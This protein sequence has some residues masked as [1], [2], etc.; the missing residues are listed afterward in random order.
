ML[1]VGAKHLRCL[2]CFFR[3][4][5]KI[6]FS[7][8]GIHTETMPHHE[9]LESFLK[10]RHISRRA[11]LQYCSVIASVLALPPSAIPALADKLRRS[12][13]P[14]VIWLSFQECTGCTESLTRS[15][16][17]TIEDLMFDFLSLDYHHTLQAASGV[18]AEI[19]REETI[20]Q[21]FGKYIL[22]VDGSIPAAAGGIYSTIAGRTNLDMLEEAAKGAATVIAVGSCSAFGGIAAANPNPTGATGISMLMDKGLIPRKP[23]VNLPGCPPLPIAVSGV[24]ANIIAFGRLPE[25]DNLKRPLSIYGKTVHERCSRL[26]YFRRRR[27]ARSFDDYGAKKG[28]CL[29][30]LGCKGPVS[31][32]ACSQF[33][34]NQGT[35]FPVE[36]GHPCLGCS[37]P[38]FWDKGSFYRQ[39]RRRRGRRL[40]RL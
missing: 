24:L 34:W 10:G 5:F 16:V 26:R 6:F 3:C 21:S 35:S 13:R 7:A 17:P 25:L 32:N 9:T 19:A 20:E 1:F 8:C 15:H 18:A 12:T 39:L 28:W 40:R 2:N 29:F 11:F 23:L 38:G 27:F 33:R 22:I 31:H 30:K 4:L 36:S 37:E 14:P